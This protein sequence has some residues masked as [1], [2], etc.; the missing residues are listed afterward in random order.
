[1]ALQICLSY[2]DVIKRTCVYCKLSNK[3]KAY[4]FSNNKYLSSKQTTGKMIV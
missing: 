3:Y 2:Y 1:M 4:A